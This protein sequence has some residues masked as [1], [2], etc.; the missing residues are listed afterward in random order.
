MKRFISI[1]ALFVV[2]IAA[3]SQSGDVWPIYSVQTFDLDEEYNITKEYEAKNVAGYF[4]FVNN[5]EFFHVTDNMTSL[6]KIIKR[7][8]GESDTVY[9]VASEVGNV[10]TFSFS[11]QKKDVVLFSSKGFGNYYKVLTP[12]KTKVFDNMNQ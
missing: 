10:Y 7:E 9:T 4:M 2:S 8:P 11:K 3:F 1:C 5:N 6:Y 12:Y